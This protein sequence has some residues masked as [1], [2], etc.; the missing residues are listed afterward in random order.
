MKRRLLLSLTAATA[1][2]LALPLTCHAEPAQCGV[3]P[4]LLEVSVKLPHLA[5]RLGAHLP[6]TV[7][8]IG[9]AST[10]GTAAG[11]PDLAYPHRLQV[12]LATYYPDV[13]IVVVNK[14][15]P[16]QSTQQMV[17]R[18][19]TDVIAENPILVVWEAGTSDAVRG[20][21]IEDFA[22]AL[23][24]GID[25]VKNRAID[26]VLVDMQ[27]SRRTSTV[28]NFEQYLTALHRV[29]DLNELYL[30]PRFEMMRYWSEQN[31]FNFNGVPKDQRAELAASVYLCIGQHL[32]ETIR[33]AV[34]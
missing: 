27:F 14:G 13:P 19:P 4:E 7:V 6:V 29:S 21:E 28:I 24:S 11:G 15:E 5:E 32:A 31:V 1:A 16:R 17:E 33:I 30:F 12:A 25:E 18:F 2:S 26:I 20:I 8:A 22:T 9:G 23:Q 3:P 10:K 34:R